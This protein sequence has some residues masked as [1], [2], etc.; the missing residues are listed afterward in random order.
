MFFTRSDSGPVSPIK[1]FLKL[2]V[3]QSGFI[4]LCLKTNC[5]K[6]GVVKVS[7]DA[8]KRA[9]RALK[10]KLTISSVNNKIKAIVILNLILNIE[11]SL[12]YTEG[13]LE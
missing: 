7:L 8:G 1:K 12:P 2:I 10:L 5:R 4:I 3:I 13:K 11:D 9:R 6:I